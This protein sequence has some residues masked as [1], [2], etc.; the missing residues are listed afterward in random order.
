MAGYDGIDAISSCKMSLM[1]EAKEERILTAVS[2][3]KHKFVKNIDH[4]TKIP[5][6]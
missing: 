6:K 5:R 2:T 4:G 1:L 3:R